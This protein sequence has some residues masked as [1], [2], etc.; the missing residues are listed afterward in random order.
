MQGDEGTEGLIS[1]S[2][3]MQQEVITNQAQLQA[4]VDATRRHLDTISDPW[5]ALQVW[6]EPVRQRTE[7]VPADATASQHVHSH[8]RLAFI[9]CVSSAAADKVVIIACKPIFASLP[10]STR[11]THVHLARTAVQDSRKSVAKRKRERGDDPPPKRSP[12]PTDTGRAV[13]P[14][15][16][17]P[18]PEPASAPAEPRPTSTSRDAVLIDHVGWLCRALSPLQPLLLHPACSVI[19][20]S[21]RLARGVSDGNLGP[22]AALLEAGQRIQ[23]RGGAFAHPLPSLFL[24]M[25]AGL[26]LCGCWD[27]LVVASAPPLL[28]GMT[29]TRAAAVTGE[30]QQLSD[31]MA[32]Y[33]SVLVHVWKDQHHALSNLSSD[34][35]GAAVAQGV[36]GSGMLSLITP[37]QRSSGGALLPLAIQTPP[38]YLICKHCGKAGQHYHFECATSAFG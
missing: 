19:T 15:A 10:A 34:E 5:L 30:E 24:Q 27:V 22:Y 9:T 23:R 8:A 4:W 16:P 28:R 26:W 21:T 32:E 29:R 36:I 37:P 6:A 2:P 35:A 18:A 38:W 13:D 20:A 12:P 7:S 17:T 14:R 25:E 11:R 31:T 3:A 1:A 33:M